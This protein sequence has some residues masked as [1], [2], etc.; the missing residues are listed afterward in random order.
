MSIASS[1]RTCWG[2]LAPGYWVLVATRI[3]GALCYAGF[4]GVAVATGAGLVPENAR[5]RAVAIIAGGL[6]LATIVGVPTG[7]ALSQ[8]A[9]W[10]SV[11]WA[12]AV[13]T[14]VSLACS[15]FTVRADAETSEQP[16]SVAA[17][18]RAM[19][20]P[21]TVVVVRDHLVGLR[22]GRRHLR[23]PRPGARLRAGHRGWGGRHLGRG[24][25][26]RGGGAA[27]TG[28]L[29]RTTLPSSAGPDSSGCRGRTRTV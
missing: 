19:A 9:G 23:L 25:A 26:D 24:A 20:R 14:A 17:E 11:F 16:R 1:A 29:A 22:L 18:L 7:T 4:W 27:V 15:L 3:V 13:L 8:L 28:Q 2:A 6:T 5:S 21:P 10:R 12:V